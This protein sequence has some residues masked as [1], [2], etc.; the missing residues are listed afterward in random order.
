MVGGVVEETGTVEEKTQSGCADA[1]V[2][3]SKTV[4]PRNVVR[5]G[6]GWK[7]SCRN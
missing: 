3:K 2:L 4:F 7:F 1:M 5:T 6:E